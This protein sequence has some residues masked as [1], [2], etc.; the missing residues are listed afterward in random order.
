MVKTTKITN[1]AVIKAAIKEERA[2]GYRA[3]QLVGH[4]DAI[5]ASATNFSRLVLARPETLK[6]AEVI[7]GLMLLLVNANMSYLLTC[8]KQV[9][10]GTN[11]NRGAKVEQMLHPLSEKST[12]LSSDF[13]PLETSG[14]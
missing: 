6:D 5:V 2:A 7:D 4:L 10:E 11:G 1:K 12:T 3:A 14:T 9:G 8:A 13:P